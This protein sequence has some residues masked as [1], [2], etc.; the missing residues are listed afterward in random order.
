MIPELGR[1]AVLLGLAACSVGA[2]TGMW[3]GKTGRED[4]WRWTRWMALA[5][6]VAIAIATG[7]M[8]YALITHDYS[9]KYVAEVGS[10][11]TPLAFTIVSLWSSLDGSILL[12]ALILAIWAGVFAVKLKDTH[13]E[14]A[15][16]ALG[17]IL[18]VGVFFTFLVSEI[19]RAFV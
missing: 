1:A 11:E 6:M 17:S 2:V 12:W 9:V 7:L 19:G 4:V 3:A 10:N 13:P 15:P 14:H 16:W 18:L 8:E 5:F